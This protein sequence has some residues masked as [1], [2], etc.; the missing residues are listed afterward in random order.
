MR[1][2]ARGVLILF[3]GH[4]ELIEGYA[5]FLSPG[6][7]IQV[8][9]DP[10]GNIIV[11]MTTGTMEIAR[12]GTVVNETHRHLSLRVRRLGWPS[13]V[14]AFRRIPKIESQVS[15]STKR[16]ARRSRPRSRLEKST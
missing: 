16:G 4:P 8:P 7:T 3:Q 14:S 5:T 1:E 6:N 15:R 11:T 13:R 10:L 9:I 2:A 12:D